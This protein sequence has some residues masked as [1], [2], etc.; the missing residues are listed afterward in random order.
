MKSKKNECYA[1]PVHPENE[2]TRM[3][4]IDPA[5]LKPLDTTEIAVPF[6][7]Q[8]LFRASFSALALNYPDVIE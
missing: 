1:R 4:K 2:V 8:K 6:G 5:D 3:G 7:F